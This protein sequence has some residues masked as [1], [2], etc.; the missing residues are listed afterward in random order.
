MV[1][2]M[3]AFK[4]QQAN[5]VEP[6]QKFPGNDVRYNILSQYAV[7]SVWTKY[8][9]KACDML[10]KNTKS[11]NCTYYDPLYYDDDNNNNNSN[12]NNDDNDD[13]GN[14]KCCTKSIMNL[15]PYYN[16]REASPKRLL[17]VTE[18]GILLFIK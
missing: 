11:S 5:Y 15:S 17:C 12:N 13:D 6:V 4:N 7:Y 1:L 10:G 14:N 2:K 3:T 8:R 16:H 9:I 18:A